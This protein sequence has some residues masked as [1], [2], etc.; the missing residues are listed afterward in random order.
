MIKWVDKL[1]LLPLI[2]VAVFCFVIASVFNLY[3]ESVL[4]IWLQIPIAIG[5][6]HLVYR[7]RMNPLP[8]MADPASA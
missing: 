2:V 6:G 1:P 4:P 3:P 8:L 5:M 7:K